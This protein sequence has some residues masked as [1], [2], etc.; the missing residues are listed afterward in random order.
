MEVLWS[1]WR[2]KYIETFKDE[3]KTEECFLCNAA[4]SPEKDKELL[5]VARAENCFAILNRYPYNNGH[6]L[7][8][9][10]RHVGEIEL[11]SDEELFDMMKF[12]KR[13]VKALQEE[14]NPHG[15]NIGINLGRVA[16][17]G[18]PGHI[19]IH[20]VPRWNGDTSFTAV[21]SDIKVV[22]QSL[23]DTQE[24]LSNI[25]ANIIKE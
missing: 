5:V 15:Y 23:E 12:V 3:S 17:A 16:G 1:P 24:I 9:P 4:N 2:S 19:H 22:S 6:V 8:A 10:Y 21:L 20:I 11:L 7:I 13:G 18:L 25:F 14:F